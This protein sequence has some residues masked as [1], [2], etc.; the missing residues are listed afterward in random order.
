MSDY[1]KSTNFTVKDSLPSGNTNK[2]VRGSELD[3]EFTNIQTA[4]ATKV[5]KNN[6]AHTGTATMES[7]SF[8]GTIDG[9]GTVNGGTY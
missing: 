4:V 6:G 9:T 2:V 5:E 8:S 7:I 1:T 3:A